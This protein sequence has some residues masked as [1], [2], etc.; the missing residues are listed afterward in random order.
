[1]T[2]KMQTAITIIVILSLSFHLTK[3][4]WA[5]FLKERWTSYST[6]INAVQ[7]CGC[8]YGRYKATGP[9]SRS[10]VSTPACNLHPVKV[11]ATETILLSSHLQSSKMA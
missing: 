1:M 2:S 6:R 8:R 11:Q 5:L 4:R 3:Q 7:G 9:V 10:W